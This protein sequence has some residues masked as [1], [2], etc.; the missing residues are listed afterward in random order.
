MASVWL[1]HLNPFFWQGF[2]FLLA[3]FLVSLSV[4]ALFGFPARLLEIA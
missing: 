1:L 2:V 3:G 4:H